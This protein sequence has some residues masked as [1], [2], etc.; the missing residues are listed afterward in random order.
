MREGQRRLRV[1]EK[2]DRAARYLRLRQNESD[3]KT[4]TGTLRAQQVITWLYWFGWVYALISSAANLGLAMG[5]LVM[6]LLLA[7]LALLRLRTVQAFRERSP[8]LGLLTIEVLFSIV[9]FYATGMSRSPAA[10]LAY[11]LIGVGAAHLRTRTLLAYTTGV[12]VAFLLPLVP[13]LSPQG[14]PIRWA[15]LITG[16]LS[17]Y[18]LSY[19]I[20]YLVESE[21]RERSDRI[22][23]Q[24]FLA[25]SRRR[26]NELTALQRI[27][28]QLSSTLELNRLLPMIIEEVVAATP[29]SNGSL[30]L[31]DE[32]TGRL[33]LRASC[34]Y[35]PEQVLAY[36]KIAFDQVRTVVGRVRSSG[37]PAFIPDVQEDPDYYPFVPETRSEVTVPVRIGNVVVGVLDLE[38]RMTNA[39]S[40]ED[41]RFVEA[42][43][44]QA[45]LALANAQLYTVTD[46]TLARRVEELSAMSEIT[47]ELAST[48]DLH[49]VLDLLIARAIQATGATSAL[50]GLYDPE[51]DTLEL[52]AQRNYPSFMG[53][54]D[55]E[56][57][58]SSGG[59]TMRVARTGRPALVADVQKD[60]DYLP[61]LPDTRSQL[62]VPIRHENQ[63][64]GV[65]NLESSRPAAFTSENL[66]FV[67]NLANQA[68]VAVQNA[69][70]YEQELRRIQE[71]SLLNEI[72]QTIAGSLD[73]EAT[74][75]T[76]LESAKRLLDY[77]VAEVNLW[78]D[79]R[80]AMITRASAGEAQPR[81]S[82]GNVYT[83]EQGYTGWITQNRKPLFISDTRTRKDVRPRLDAEE[84]PIL[85]YMGVPLLKGQKLVGTLEMAADRP[86]AFSQQDLR[87]LQAISGQA[88]VAIENARLYQESETRVDEM[89]GLFQISGIITSTLDLDQLLEQTLPRAAQLLRAEKMALLLY[90]ETTKRLEA[91]AGGVVGLPPEEADRLSIDAQSPEFAYGVFLT[92][93]PFRSADAINDRRIIPAYFPLIQKYGFRTV[94]SVP[95]R[96]HDATLG[97]LHAGN[98]R[99][100]AFTAED[101]RLLATIAAQLATGIQNVRLYRRTDEQLRSQVGQ[102]TALQRITRELNATL[103]LERI[104]E[105]VITEAIGATRSSHGN[106]AL[107]DV[108]QGTFHVVAHQGYTQQEVAALQKM[109]LGEG[110]SVAEDAIH[111]AKSV[112]VEDAR[113]E[114]RP[115]CTRAATRSAVA[116]PIL[117][118]GTVAGVINLRAME[119]SA[120]DEDTLEFLEGLANQAGVAIG[121]AW[122]YQ[123]QVRLGGS[124]SRRADQL[125]SLL[126]IGN[127]LRMNLSLEE[128]L[129]QIVYAI[130][131]AAGFNLALLSVVEGDPPILRRVAAAGLP[132]AVFEEMRQ[133][134]QP[135]ER[136]SLIMRDEFRISQ[137]YLFPHQRAREWE[138]GL[139]IY[140]PPPAEDAEWEEG[141]WHPED[142]LV[143]PLH[144]SDGHIL[145]LLSV[146]EPRDGRIPTRATIEALEIFANQA[147]IAMENAQLYQTQLA[148]SQLMERRAEQLGN[149]LNFGNQLKA[150][151]SLKQVCQ[152]IADAAH[153]QMGYRLVA[154]NL[155]DSKDPSLVQVVAAAGLDDGAQIPSAPFAR[156]A[157]ENLLE[158]RYRISQSFLI[159]G[160]ELLAD[161]GAPI[162]KPNLGARADD[163]W[164]P[165]DALIV[166][167]TG[168]KGHIGYLSLDDPASRRRPEP[169]DIAAL[170]VFA[171]QAAIGIENALLYENVISR[172]REV[173]AMYDVSRGLVSTLDRQAMLEDVLSTLQKSAGYA[174]CAL[175]LLD[176]KT[177]DLLVRAAVGYM[178]DIKG[179]RIQVGVEGVTGWV[180]ENRKPLIVP[181]VSQDARYIQ[182]DLQTRAEIA[183]P[184]M[185]GDRVIG[186][187]DAQSD[188]VN[189]FGER[190]LRIL[191]AVAAQTAVALENTR[192]YDETRRRAAQLEA[193]S[194][195]GRRIASILGIDELLG[196]VVELVHESF[197]YDHVHVF[198]IDAE[199]QEAVYKAGNGST[200]RRI[201]EE[202]LRLKVGQEGMIG[203]AASTAQPMIANDVTKDPHYV[204]HPE[205]AN[206]RSECTVPLIIGDR[207]IGVLDVQSNR[208]D[209]FGDD[210]LFLLQALSDQLAIAIENARLF[211]ESDRRIRSMTAL[212]KMGQAIS[213][214]LDPA[215]LLEEIYKQ[216]RQVMDAA[217]F[218]IALYDENT[219]EVS[220]PFAVEKGQRQVWEPM[221]GGNS[222]TEHVIRTRRSVF[223]PDNVME[224]VRELGME[225]VGEPA[226]SWMGVP[227]ISGEKC[228]GCVAV[229]HYEKPRA[230]TEED[231]NLLQ[232]IA[233]QMA[234]A[235]E[236]A[237]LF[238]ETRQGAEEMRLLYDLGVAL[239][240]TL[241]LDKVLTLIAES[242]LHLTHTNVATLYVKG[243][244]KKEDL[245]FKAVADPPEIAEH[246]QARK[247]RAKGLTAH[248]LRSGETLVVEDVGR[249]ERVSSVIKTMGVQSMMGVPIQV[250][251][252]TVGVLFAGSLEPHH[253]TTRELSLIAFLV[254]QA[255]RAIRNAQLYQEITRLNAELEE[256][257]EQRTRELADA[258]KEITS[259]RDRTEAL[260]RI[261]R[262]LSETL[263]LN[264]VMARA[265][266]LLKESVG[267]KHGSILLVDQQT[268]KL[269]YRASLGREGAL[270]QK[271]QP[272]PYGTGTGLAGWVLTNRKAAIVPNVM[273][274][275]RWAAVQGDDSVISALSVPLQTGEDILGILTLTDP[276]A[277]YF[278]EVHLK[279]VTAAATQIATAIGNAELYRLIQ[280][281]ADRLGEMLRLQQTEASKNRAILEGI[282]D[283]VVVTD[284]EGRIILFNSAAERI[285]GVPRDVTVGENVH[286]LPATLSAGAEMAARGLAAVS[287]WVGVPA[288]NRPLMEERFAVGNKVAS[289]RVA[290]VMMGDELLGTAALFRDISKEVEAER[291]KNEF[292]S[293]V[294]HELRTPMTSI[295]GYTDLLFMQAA[296]PITDGQHKFLTVIKSNA[297]RLATLVNDLLDISRI[298]TG[299]IRL[300]RQPN[301]AAR[302][303]QEVVTALS[304][305]AD[306]KDLTLSARIR[307]ALPPVYADRDR[308]TQILTNLVDNACRYTPAGGKITVSAR[309]VVDKV[310][311]DV[312]DTGIGIS[313][314][315]Q[316]KIFDRFYRADHPVVQETG[317]TGLG[318]AIVKS[319]VELHGGTLWVKSDPGKGSTFSFTMP[320]AVFAEPLPPLEEP[321]EGAQP[322]GHGKHIL[323]VEDDAD[324][325]NLVTQ[326]LRETG[327][328]V[329]ISTRGDEVLEIARNEKPDL[330]ALDV[331]LPGRDGFEVLQ[332][333]K[334]DPETED[335]PVVILSIV[336]DPDKAYRLG[337]VDYLAKP[338]DEQ[339]LVSTIHSVLFS[340][341]MVLICDDSEDTQRL[342]REVL[343]RYG[344]VA[345]SV[346]DGRQVLAV[347]EKERPGLILLDLKMPGLDGYAVLEQLKRNENTRDI[348]V[349]VITASIT[350]DRARREKAIAL[351]AANLM[352][353]PFS[354]PELV[355]EVRK[356]LESRPG[357]REPAANGIE[358][359]DGEAQA[360]TS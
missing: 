209:A 304:K 291:V 319:F 327:Y 28:R 333:L 132:I 155:V 198:L 3:M 246:L 268:G 160:G 281:Q 334:L 213:A 320:I 13:P 140:T 148:Q 54:E 192:L 282:A 131:D 98:K 71:V 271:G 96:T 340:R 92:G 12:A 194:E 330:I 202:A 39:F 325:A 349:I 240:E 178:E 153:D 257:V 279:M 294:S 137:S 32:N 52:L 95:L 177:N 164:Q 269:V 38:A 266:Q 72:G 31:V 128:V 332:D 22:E 122:R 215:S 274:D 172:M 185:I 67:E 7:Q 336:T 350:D 317:G 193:T 44:D 241:D 264:R 287:K 124:L 267:M 24:D 301:D 15:Y 21:E 68:A 48:L 344:F 352:T 316:A 221:R 256:R 163:E 217:E 339:R 252:E 254:N 244:A 357:V 260:Y 179:M 331:R 238:Q 233:T 145:G 149:L 183:V 83:P 73:L 243:H 20:R 60:P 18:A 175:L 293:T 47:R 142:M 101:E 224:G 84:F 311:V 10:I 212:N 276:R 126:E 305:Q 346:S 197:N 85:C 265:L 326:H 348:P 288:R 100:G 141:R 165:S 112:I 159:T 53:G 359:P 33:T 119:P 321:P 347:A 190:D 113:Q 253:F 108:E 214:T 86:G 4:S 35:S 275:K 181:D 75:S 227:M 232:T 302:I 87:L 157:L 114:T 45:A 195:V 70:L 173:S 56:K 360:G 186:V 117:Y 277:D 231:L 94:L 89:S 139:H 6:V 150:E 210:D 218:Y 342:L 354:I 19:I 262:E 174:N 307:A 23:S 345:R 242:T 338:V 234:T 324:I 355:E 120:F 134:R 295:K 129:D 111:S 223:L 25:D 337:A 208:E 261:A 235:V 97:E 58:A 297:D 50:A 323:V 16:I 59:I 78:D 130:P 289:V 102:M 313:P 135:L 180:A 312:T 236:N 263:D 248:I 76:I 219:Q 273:K 222:L 245:I 303:I 144:A 167:L 106:I 34:G 74:L 27:S 69:R 216:I 79:E 284:T 278:S 105:V 116:V 168:S 299:R 63:V 309:R 228:I 88:A 156:S 46:Q 66:D 249:D 90:N 322:V 329:S 239:S 203:H 93:R 220:F 107:L 166:P 30:L 154:L 207:V 204:S 1:V 146:D 351:G 147:A 41:V 230:Y 61:V 138:E 250:G 26:I 158:D 296:G 103:E 171:N 162:Y 17:Y 2:L 170:E 356:T 43:A 57:A 328:E 247:P 237:R 121:N 341:D 55:G 49:R 143:V 123:E 91:Q 42:I 161:S 80:Q 300:D 29:A 270:P 255:S 115:V 109:V 110:N 310:Q 298:E 136:F 280:E 211:E 315:D 206:T 200:G 125:N 118:E 184:L 292:I 191:A 258:N 14:E 343:E 201:L 5:L 182:K 152:E 358:E 151:M 127:A 353:K 64:L 318:L 40:E 272:T 77:Y 205:L 259:E 36:E 335:I 290:P 199:T 189:A 188:Q 314:E 9:A 82:V 306:E 133:V 37:Q 8:L 169:E 65:L 226:L 308:L 187:L 176:P 229:Q 11:F 283:G 104:L 51:T 251:G 225:P 285:L 99:D 81:P 286:A 62:T 196:E